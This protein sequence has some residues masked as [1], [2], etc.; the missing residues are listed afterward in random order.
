MGLISRIMDQNILGRAFKVCIAAIR[1]LTR[2]WVEEQ[3]NG[4]E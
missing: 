4:K 2:F 3:V 1:F